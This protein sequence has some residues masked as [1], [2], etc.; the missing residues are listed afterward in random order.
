MSQ[1]VFAV[2]DFV[3]L[4]KTLF[5]RIV[6][7]N[8]PWLPSEDAE[9]TRLLYELLMAEETDKRPDG[10]DTEGVEAI[11][12]HFSLYLAAMEACGAD[13]RPIRGCLDHLRKGR[14]LAYALRRF[15]IF[16][17]TCCFVRHTFSTFNEPTPAIAASFV[18]GREAMTPYFFE[19]WLAQLKRHKLPNT[20]LLIYYL[21]RHITL[22]GNE[23]FQKAARL[24]DRVCGDD[25]LAWEQAGRAAEA[26]LQA[27]LGLLAGI[28]KGI[29]FLR[30]YNN[31]ERQ[32][33][34]VENNTS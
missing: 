20:A 18:F 3:C 13:S 33:P 23:H 29:R 34:T 22:D 31:R 8:V 28:Q 2:W 14:G 7:T 4:L 9:S 5:S 11:S 15:D 25:A 17:P 27:R 6:C 12:S 19:P 10:V 32:I 21:E 26:A 24:L 16:E 30:D 1:H